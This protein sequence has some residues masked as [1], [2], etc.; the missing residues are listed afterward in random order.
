MKL[1]FEVEVWSWSRSWSLKFE[2]EAWSLKLKFEVE[3]W[4]WGLKL[5]FE[6]EVRVWSLKLMFEVEVRKTWHYFDLYHSSRKQSWKTNINLAITK[7]PMETVHHIS[8]E[9]DESKD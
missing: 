2:V 1:K 7:Y 8:S 9:K 3:F 5:R 6:V 4:S